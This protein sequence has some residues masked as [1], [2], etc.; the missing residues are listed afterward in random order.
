[1]AT[2]TATSTGAALLAAG[3]VGALMTAA[4]LSLNPLVKAVG[5]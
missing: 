2:T 1:V 4:P 5:D 3:R